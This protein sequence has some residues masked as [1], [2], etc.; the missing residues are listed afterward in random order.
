MRK[1]HLICEATQAYQAYAIRKTYDGEAPDTADIVLCSTAA[2]ADAV[3]T[4]LNEQLDG[5]GQ[6]VDGMGPESIPLSL[7][8]VEGCEWAAEFEVRP[9]LVSA[10]QLVAGTVREIKDVLAG[11]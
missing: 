1:A 9:V 4:E 5:Y 8:F 2:L 10:G 7:P 11:E 6:G 3:C